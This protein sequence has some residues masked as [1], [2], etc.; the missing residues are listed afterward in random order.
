MTFGFFRRCRKAT[1]VITVVIMVVDYIRKRYFPQRAAVMQSQKQQAVLRAILKLQA[2]LSLKS[3]LPKSPHIFL[4][5]LPWI[6][7][8][9][10][11]IPRRQG[12]WHKAKRPNDRTYRCFPNHSLLLLCCYS[13]RERGGARSIPS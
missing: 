2:F 10:R 5:I 13:F 8:S 7:R 1:T 12:R 9:L 6:F 3:V 4:T 11:Y